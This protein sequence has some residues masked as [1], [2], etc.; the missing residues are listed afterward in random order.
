MQCKR[1]GAQ[2]GIEYRLCPYCHTEIEYPTPNHQQ[3]PTII[4]QNILGNDPSPMQSPYMY[5]QY[6]NYN[7][8][9]TR[10]Q[11]TALILAIFLGWLGMERFYV[12]KAASGIMYLL[13]FG[14][15]GIGWLIDIIM[16]ACGAFTDSRNL[17]LAK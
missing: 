1:C 16:I 10:K 17:P 2:V 8:V 4:V 11:S 5:N 9:S 12:G 6:N 14:L 3:Q 13:T 15:F 7:M